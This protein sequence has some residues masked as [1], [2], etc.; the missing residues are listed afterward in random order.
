MIVN[1]FFVFDI[2][3]SS[4]EQTVELKKIGN[5]NNCIVD[6]D[7]RIKNLCST[8]VVKETLWSDETDE[9]ACYK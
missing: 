6:N 2:F 5:K 4:S 9:E 1:C 3:R 8:S 7:C